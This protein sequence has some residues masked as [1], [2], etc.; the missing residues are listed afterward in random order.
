MLLALESNVILMDAWDAL[1]HRSPGFES[2]RGGLVEASWSGQQSRFLNLA[3]TAHS[4]ETLAEFEAAVRAT[5]LWGQSRKLPWIFA[6]SHTTLGSLLPQTPAIMRKHAF[7][8]MM[9]LTAMVADALAPP[10]RPAPEFTTLTDADSAI[11][12]KVLRIND[13]ACQ[14][15][16][17]EPGTLPMERGGW[18][19][20][21]ERMASV[22]VSQ[23]VNVSSAAV[24][25]L[26]GLRYVAL[27]ATLPG[28]R[29]K[30][31]AESAVRDALHRSQAAGLGSRTY[32]HA[33][34]AGRP[35]YEQMGYKAVADYTLYSKLA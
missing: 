26:A 20:A 27:V 25:N 22:C 7:V 28:A 5:I 24:L 13:A 18:W 33:S 19:L 29:K 12:H 35:L 2:R 8:P 31:F 4:P 3:V 32:L 6:V 21:P 11:G 16:L 10:V 23:G 15:Q 14:T 9:P 34:A 1:N 30:G 17:A